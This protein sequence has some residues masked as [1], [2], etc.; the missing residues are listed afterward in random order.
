MIYWCTW[1]KFNIWNRSLWTPHAECQVNDFV[2]CISVRQVWLDIDRLLQFAVEHLNMHVNRKWFTIKLYQ[3]V[4]LRKTLLAM[5]YYHWLK[6]SLLSTS[7]EK[8]NMKI[9]ERISIM[10]KKQYFLMR[11]FFRTMA[12]TFK[13]SNLC[14]LIKRPYFIISPLIAFHISSFH[15][16]NSAAT[17]Y[18][19]NE[20]CATWM[21][22]NWKQS[23]GYWWLPSYGWCTFLGEA[24]D[25]LYF[26]IDGFNKHFTFNSSMIIYHETV[27]ADS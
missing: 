27:K 26:L 11:V 12:C 21:V 13:K 14:H 6:C 9:G 7:F 4:H 18:E 2:S 10:H 23:A 5:R 15:V 16:W 22:G 20:L 1:T 19:L 8:I 25:S 3:K 24:G 17:N